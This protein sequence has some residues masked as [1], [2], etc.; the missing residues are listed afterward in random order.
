M[1]VLKILSQHFLPLN[2]YLVSVKSNKRRKIFVKNLTHGGRRA[3]FLPFNYVWAAVQYCS[4]W[5]CS[6]IWRNPTTY[7]LILVFL[8]KLF[9]CGALHRVAVSN[10]FKVFFVTRPWRIRTKDL[11][12]FKR[13]GILPLQEFG[14][15]NVS[16]LHL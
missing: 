14:L 5:I 6:I 8:L 16:M 13:I 7:A 12:I 2:L 10:I 9:V 11:S 15:K 4:I 3:L 1:K